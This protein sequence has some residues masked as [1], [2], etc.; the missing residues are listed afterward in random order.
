MKKSALLI[1]NCQVLLPDFSILPDVAILIEGNRIARIAPEVDL[2]DPQPDTEVLDAQSKLALPGFVD[3][4]THAAQTLL[5]GS[6]VDELP[7][8][9]ARILVPFESA[10]DYETTYAGAMLFCLQNL[11]AGIT[12]F[13]D[14][15]GPHMEA[16]ADA[17]IQTGIRAVI[18]RSTM[19]QGAFVPDSMKDSVQDAIAKTEAL[20]DAY[21]DQAEGRIKIW[22]GVRQAM[23]TSA[24]LAEAISD[25]SKA[26]QTG[27]HAHL[28]EHLD[29]VSHCLRNFG[30][31]P[32]EWFNH[33]GLLGP[34]FIGAHSVRLTAD[35]IRL[36]AARDANAVHCPTSN[37][38]NHGFSKTPQ[39]LSR[40]INIGLGTDGGSG[41]RL[42]LF[43]QMR[44]LK[45]AMQARFGVEIND[46]LTIPTL[47]TLKMATSG[48][49]KAVMQQDEIGTLEEGKK[50]DILLLDM[51]QIHLSPTA[52]LPK[53]LVLNGG[54]DDITDVI[55]DGK[56]LLKD[57]QFLH[58]DETEIRR[59]AGEALLKIGKKANLALPAPY[60]G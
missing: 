40:G 1:K 43:E 22:F 18:T 25:R 49:A 8:V 48:G 55:V 26:L 57:R 38:Q 33:F 52:D 46:P 12:T 54:P 34:N 50:A 36:M 10:L 31:R 59:K 16:V 24:E 3:G 23:T 56:L 44:L 15:G 19:D 5:R 41:V 51:N 42:N 20:Y 14:A 29:E 7:M 6:V 13:A 37:L 28:A 32:A 2:P 47:E 45:N 30:L 4:H 53:T 35:E 60:T 9:W 21:N 27:V 39:M 17:A 58:L 11:R